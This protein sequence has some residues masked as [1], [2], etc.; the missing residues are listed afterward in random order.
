M[1]CFTVPWPFRRRDLVRNI[2]RKPCVLLY[3]CMCCF[4]YRCRVHRSFQRSQEDHPD[5]RCECKDRNTR[6]VVV[7]DG[8]PYPRTG[9]FL[10]ESPG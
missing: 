5:G 6:T 1:P 7:A 2:R 8:L 9:C 3:L 10:A 4:I